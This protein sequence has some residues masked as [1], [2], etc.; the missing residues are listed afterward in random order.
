MQLLLTEG[1]FPGKGQRLASITRSNAALSTQCENKARPK[2]FAHKIKQTGVIM[3]K[4]QLRSCCCE[5]AASKAAIE[6]NRAEGWRPL[7]RKQRGTEHHGAM[8][9]FHS[10]GY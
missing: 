9:R 2:A 10:S 3:A 6:N 4:T 1:C 8:R 5:K 7:T